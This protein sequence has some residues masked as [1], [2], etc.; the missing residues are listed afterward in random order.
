M[1]VLTMEA[2]RW[3]SLLVR[4]RLIWWLL[5]AAVVV[6]VAGALLVVHFMGAPPLLG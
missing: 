6:P 5:V 1:I 4:A 2:R 3:G